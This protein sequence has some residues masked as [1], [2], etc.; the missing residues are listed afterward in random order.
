MLVIIASVLLAVFYAALMEAYL[1]G[2]RA[3]PEYEMPEEW[4]P[5]AMVSVLVPARN[6]ASHIEACLRSIL[7]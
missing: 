1:R 2:W 6:E 4:V 5:T 3:L 7:S